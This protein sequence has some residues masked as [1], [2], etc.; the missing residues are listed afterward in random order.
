MG[1]DHSMAKNETDF[2]YLDSNKDIS[3]P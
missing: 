1:A 3:Q 2:R